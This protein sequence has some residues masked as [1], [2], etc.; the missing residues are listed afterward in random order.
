MTKAL[1]VV[2]GDLVVEAD[3]AC[4]VPA[5]DHE[6]EAEEAVDRLLIVLRPK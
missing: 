1:D 5:V 2:G 4:Q 3:G 6:V